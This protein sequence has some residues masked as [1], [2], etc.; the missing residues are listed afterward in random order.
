MDEASEEYQRLYENIDAVQN[1]EDHNRLKEENKEL[2]EK[3]TSLE[4]EMDSFSDEYARLF[5]NSMKQEDIDDSVQRLKEE[6]TQLSDKI[7]NLEDK[8][9]AKDK[10][11]EDF[12]EEYE[13]MFVNQQEMMAAAA[14]AAAPGEQDKNTGQL[15][16]EI[17]KLT[18]ENHSMEIALTKTHKE[19]DSFVQEFE[20]LSENASSFEQEQTIIKMEKN[21]QSLTTENQKLNQQITEMQDEFDMMNETLTELNKDYMGL[22]QKQ[23]KGTKSN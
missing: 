8:L 22:L 5:E 17:D 18:K 16:K 11:L 3:F 4:K 13:R 2:K 6:N 21:N 15:Q 20:R 9:N 10:E 12:A 1:I 23:N 14:A 7:T 19:I